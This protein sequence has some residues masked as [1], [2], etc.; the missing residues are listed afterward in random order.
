MEPS[1]PSFSSVSEN[2]SQKDEKD[3]NDGCCVYARARGLPDKADPPE[4]L[5]VF[6]QIVE[7]HPE[8]LPHQIANKYKAATDRDINGA[9]VKALKAEGRPPIVLTLSDGEVLTIPYDEE[10]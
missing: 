3:D 8:A 5:P 6:W 1:I 2:P 9:Q 4:V 10:L 7:N